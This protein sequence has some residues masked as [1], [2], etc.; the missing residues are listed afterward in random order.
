MYQVTKHL[1]SLGP[2]HL[3]YL[4]ISLYVHMCVPEHMFRY[5]VGAEAGGDQ[6]REQIPWNWSYRWL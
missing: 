1:F 5:H 6:T 2:C 4:L 3:K